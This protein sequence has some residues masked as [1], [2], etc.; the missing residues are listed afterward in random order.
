[1]FSRNKE[2]FKPFGKAPVKT[3]EKTVKPNSQSKNNKNQEPAPLILEWRHRWMK[4]VILGALFGYLGGGAFY[5]MYYHGDFY[6]AEAEKRI[7]RKEVIPASRGSILDRSGHPLA[8]NAK[9]YDVFLDVKFFLEDDPK[10]GVW[11]DTHPEHFQRLLEFL[12][13]TPDKFANRIKG[14]ENSRYLILAKKIPDVEY[15]YLKSLKIKGLGFEDSFKRFYLAGE[16]MGAILGFVDDEN[17]GVE[18]VEKSFDTP[19]TGRDGYHKFRKDQF[20]KIVEELDSQMP[21]NGQDIT[22]SIDLPLQQELYRIA[23]RAYIANNSN[24]VSATMI[25]I[26]SGEIVAMVN[27]PSFN[28]NDRRSLLDKEKLRNKNVT[29]L[30]EPGSTVKP[31]VV[32]TGLQDGVI[33]E[34]S[35]FNTTPLTVNG[36][37]IKDVSYQR[38]LGLAEILQKSS[39]TGVSQI[40]LLMNPYRLPETYKKVGFGSMV[41]SGL[42]AEQAGFVKNLKKWSSIDQA[43]LAYGYGL[44]ASPLQIAQAY[45]V[46][47]NKGARKPISILKISPP[48]T[49]A[50]VLDKKITEKIL[51]YLEG[52]TQYNGGGG[53]A[54]VE[55][56]RVGVK[57]GTAKKTQNGRYVDKYIAYTAGIAPIDKPKF[58]L[59]VVV[60]EPRGA[61]YYGG[62]VAAPVFSEMMASALRRF[63]IRPPEFNILKQEYPSWNS[64]QIME[65]LKKRHRVEDDLIRNESIKRYKYL[66]SVNGI[67]VTK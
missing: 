42:F 58:A 34:N 6:R 57:T 51:K 39:N 31:F 7:V 54:R 14:K 52:V 41:D 66:Q 28:P 18:G 30:F 37:T 12:N 65:E 40:S 67:R 53:A 36:F 63:N 5:R 61:K 25:D 29:D 2:K 16:E 59:V 62:A 20:G 23:K 46:L 44:M 24:S 8:I 1:M 15:N 10:H 48:Y 50:Q 32:L 47:A 21:F 26:E 17:Q 56:F 60:D 45:T 4:V 64:L 35:I 3:I 11:K 19:L 43:N 22:L 33:N 38:N 13:D 27:A 9:T 49:S 55:N